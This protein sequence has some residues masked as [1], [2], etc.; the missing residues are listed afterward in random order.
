MPHIREVGLDQSIHSGQGE[1]LN[2]GMTTSHASL[3]L[4][5]SAPG[6]AP[7]QDTDFGYQISVP[8]SSIS[9]GCPTSSR[10]DHLETDLALNHSLQATKDM[11]VQRNHARLELEMA[12]LRK[13]V[14]R[15]LKTL[16]GKIT[17]VQKLVPRS[18]EKKVQAALNDPEMGDFIYS[19]LQGHPVTAD[20]YL[21]AAE[22]ADA[23]ATELRTKAVRATGDTSILHR[24]FRREDS[25][26][27]EAYIV[28]A[29]NADVLATEFRLMADRENPALKQPVKD[30]AAQTADELIHQHPLKAPYTTRTASPC[31]SEHSV[32]ASSAASSYEH[33]TGVHPS[34]TVVATNGD[35]TAASPSWKP[36]YIAS[37]APASSDILSK[38][39]CSSETFTLD[40]ITRIL[41][42]DNAMKWSPGFYY[43]PKP[44]DTI[45]AGRSLWLLETDHEPFLPSEPG[46]H[47]A[48]LTA[49]FNEGEGQDTRT[50]P[51]E[52]AYAN[53]PVFIG[54][55]GAYKYFGTYS[56]LR[57]SDK[58]DY[59]TLK[60]R[61]PASVKT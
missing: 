56:Q 49:F 25:E 53:V 41:S 21:A 12:E 7:L 27:A 17:E 31:P 35:L 20:V 13:L 42:N 48:K 30:T 9:T 44:A 6:F 54:S 55:N 47:G 39:P 32:K 38:I 51:D 52:S 36:I 1:T 23:V 59:D 40:F 11:I 4:N 58:V 29:E 46:E 50:I 26:E 18:H 45:L 2:P 43:I 3:R 8:Y 22:K 28:Q 14:T 37:L 60:E 10:V 34:S 57:Y 61:V 19:Y 5:P 24:L 16:D 33:V 15:D